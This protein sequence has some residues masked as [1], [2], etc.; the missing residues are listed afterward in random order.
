MANTTATTANMFTVNAGSVILTATAKHKGSV[1]GF[2][3]E[4]KQRGKG[5][6]NYFVLTVK[7]NN[8][9]RATFNYYGSINDHSKGI[10]EL[11]ET[12]IKEALGCVL[13][14]ANSAA[15]WTST[16]DVMDEFGYD[17][18]SRSQYKQAKQ[19][20]KGCQAAAEKMAKL[21]LSQH[22]IEELCDQL[23][24]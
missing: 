23:N 22:D 7:S 16:D 18:D 12:G 17:T 2:P 4:P 21:G 1:F 9:S 15:N 8:G 24:N 13:S 20:F 5:Y 14:D 6:H 11:G 19:V 3:N 10:T